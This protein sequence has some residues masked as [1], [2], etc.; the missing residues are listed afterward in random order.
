MVPEVA[1]HLCS[2]LLTHG[3]TPESIALG[4]CNAWALER[5]PASY[6]S[7]SEDESAQS[8]CPWPAGTVQPA[9][10]LAERVQ[11]CSS[12]MSNTE[13]SGL[14]HMRVLRT[15][16][17]MVAALL[18]WGKRRPLTLL[19]GGKHPKKGE[20]DPSSRPDP[21]SKT[22]LA[23]PV[24]GASTLPHVITKPDARGHSTSWNHWNE[25]CTRFQAF[26]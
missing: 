14:T 15:P 1:Y 3:L 8:T 2:S 7:H 21:Y 16:S 12:A 6:S 22:W 23:L 11:G 4:S 20:N 19:R 10:R 25:R 17:A 5:P 26:K 18:R 9:G 13:P 24:A